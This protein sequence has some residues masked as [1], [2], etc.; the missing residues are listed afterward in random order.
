MLEINNCPV[1]GNSEFAHFLTCKDYTVSGEKFNIVSCEDC[2]FKFTNPRPE[3]SK[4]GAYY[5]SEDYISHSDT[6]KGFLAK[7]Y[8]AVRNYT[9]KGK[10]KLI[11]KYVSR[12]TILDYGCGTGTFLKVCKDNGW[13]VFGM[14]PDEGARAIGIKQGLVADG[15]KQ[16]LQPKI[17]NRQLDIITLWHVLEHVTDLELTLTFFNLKLKENG[18]LIIAVPNYTSYDARH[19]GAFWAAYD[20]PRH[21]YHFEVQTISTLLSKFGFS[22]E[23]CIPMKFDSYYVSMLS[24]KYKTG[25]INYFK[26]FISGFKSNAMAKSPKEYSSVIYVF[27]R[28]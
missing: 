4:L 2:N 27:K 9:L 15:D 28:A 8:H 17:R 3:D 11:S 1:C 19:Y 26:A 18:R 24:E 10:L 14:E 25:S 23:E 21:L 6:R 12:G 16:S 7:L 5:K 20:V 22:L 13:E